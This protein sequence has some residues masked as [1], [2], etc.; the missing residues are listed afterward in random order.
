MGLDSTRSR[1][2]RVLIAFLV[3]GFA[4]CAGFCVWEW[5]SWRASREARGELAAGRYSEAARV[6]R[7]WILLRPRSAEA[8]FVRA[9]AAIAVGNRRDVLDGMVQARALGCPEEKIALL[10]SFLDA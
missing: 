3:A 8:Q 5:P 7:R 10:R 9:K 6:A 1:K 2:R 4:G